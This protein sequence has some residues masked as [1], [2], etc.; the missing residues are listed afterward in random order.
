MINSDTVARYTTDTRG[1]VEA[2]RK[3]IEPIASYMATEEE[4]QNFMHGG[5]QTVVQ[6]LNILH[7]RL[8]Q[9]IE[10]VLEM[11]SENESLTKMRENINNAIGILEYLQRTD[12][13][14]SDDED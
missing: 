5:I 2:V 12:P 10:M 9:L 6:N 13:A 7:E 1:L 14:P 3:Y 4:R 11:G 8:D